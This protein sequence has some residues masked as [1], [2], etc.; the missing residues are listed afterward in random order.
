M[1]SVRSCWYCLLVDLV[2]VSYSV[3]TSRPPQ[4]RLYS[5]FLDDAMPMLLLA[6]CVAKTAPTYPQ[7]NGGVLVL[8]SWINAGPAT[9][10]ACTRICRKKPAHFCAEIA[11]DGIS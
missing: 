8:S 5:C 6:S 4:T 7:T 9:A 1:L 3:C 11:G 2:G 10:V